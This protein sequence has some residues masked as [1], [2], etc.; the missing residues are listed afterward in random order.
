MPW[1]HKLSSLLSAFLKFLLFLWLYYNHIIFPLPP[2]P[3]IHYFEYL[4][5]FMPPVLLIVLY[6]YTHIHIFKY[7]QLSL[8]VS[9]VCFSGLTTLYEI[10]SR[11]AFLWEKTISLT[12]SIL[13]LPL[14]CCLGFKLSLLVYFGMSI[15]VLLQLKLR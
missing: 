5:K 3:L 13:Y 8:Y 9:P 15:G 4:F 7:N 14:V 6:T 2:K 1:C 10:A 12:F 11:C